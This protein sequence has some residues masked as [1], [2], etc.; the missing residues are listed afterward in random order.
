MTASA[1]GGSPRRR[2][3]P[4]RVMANPELNEPPPPVQPV[5]PATVPCVV[6]W[7][8][9][10]Q[11][12]FLT[13]DFNAWTQDSP[14]MRDGNEFWQVLNLTPGRT[15]HYKFV[16]DGE[17]MYAPDHSTARDARGNMSNYIQVDHWEPNVENDVLTVESPRSSYATD[18]PLDEDQYTKEPPPVPAH[19]MSKQ[20]SP[21][22]MN[23]FA[24]AYCAVDAVPPPA[25]TSGLLAAA[26]A[27]AGPPVGG[28]G[29]GDEG[30]PDG[31]MA[32]EIA[33]AFVSKDL[34]AGVSRALSSSLR[35]QVVHV[36]S[37]STAVNRGA[38]VMHRIFQS[39]R[40]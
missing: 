14:M 39:L 24:V 13:G 21:G 36:H 9:P 30:A 11:N 17:W 4:P 23:D 20:A 3:S 19:L 40:M 38:V 1:D 25:T 35:V 32:A 12:V 8:H 2:L 34:V 27:A 18:L 7:K 10:G 16:V 6:T 33:P 28:G 22:Y 29:V 5:E 37:L 15:Y 26:G 31:G